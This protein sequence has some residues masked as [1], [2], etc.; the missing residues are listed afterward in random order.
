LING[1][2]LQ[3]EVPNASALEEEGFVTLIRYNAHAPQGK[4]TALFNWKVSAMEIHPEEDVVLVLLLCTATMRSVAD[5]G[6]KHHGNLFAQ[7]RHKESKPGLKD[8]GSVV[9]DHATS[10]SNLASWYLNTPQLREAEDG[11]ERILSH[12]GPMGGACGSSCQAGADMGGYSKEHGWTLHKHQGWREVTID[13][14]SVGTMGAWGRRTG[15][16]IQ[17]DLSRLPKKT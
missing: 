14:S 17:L 13:T 16:G 10:Q 3:Y 6:G 7:R 9:V 12:A 4:A 2:K 5:F 1:R 15:S 8:W 11:T